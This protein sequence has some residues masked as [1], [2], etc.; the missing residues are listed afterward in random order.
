MKSTDKR[1]TYWHQLE[2]FAATVAGDN[3]RN[4]TNHNDSNANMRVIDA[5]YSAAGLPPRQPTP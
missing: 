2:A 3:D 5:V 1:T 4:L